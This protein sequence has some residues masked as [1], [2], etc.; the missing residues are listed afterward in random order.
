M[1]YFFRLGIENLDSYFISHE[2]SLKLHQRSACMSLWHLGGS[3]GREDK[4][5]GRAEEERKVAP[6]V[7]GKL[8]LLFL[9][10]SVVSEGGRG[11]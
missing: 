8:V 10:Q 1:I 2:V 6:C 7:T 4:A 3:V 9:L 5:N 11:R